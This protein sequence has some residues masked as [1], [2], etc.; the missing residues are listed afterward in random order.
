[1][2]DIQHNGTE[3]NGRLLLCWVSIMGTV[4]YADCH[5]LSHYPEFCYTECHYG[6]CHYTEC[7]YGECH[8]GEC[9]GAVGNQHLL[10]LD[11]I[12]IIFL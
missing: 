11:K 9:R 12:R 2:C 8:Y 3:H 4:M 5:K 7:H 10:K 1:M 6:E